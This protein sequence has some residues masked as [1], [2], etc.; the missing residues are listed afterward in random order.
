MVFGN[1]QIMQELLQQE[2]E[3]TAAENEELRKKLEECQA[4]NAKLISLS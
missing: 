4:E 2:T 3:Q 1:Y